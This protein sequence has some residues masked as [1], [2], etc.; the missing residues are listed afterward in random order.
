MKFGKQ[1]GPLPNAGVIPWEMAGVGT[2]RGVVIAWD[3][4]R[5]ERVHQLIDAIKA[6][7]PTEPAF[8]SEHEAEVVLA[9]RGRPPAKFS[10]GETVHVGDDAWSIRYSATSM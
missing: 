5:D 2:Y 9:W 4:D 3:H 6:D 1:K 8:V 10:K 7:F